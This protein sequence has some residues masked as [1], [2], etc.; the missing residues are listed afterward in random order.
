MSKDGPGLPGGTFRGSSVAGAL[1]V[2]L[3]RLLRSTLN[4][5]FILIFLC[6]ELDAVPLCPVDKEVIRSQEVRRS[7]AWDGAASVLG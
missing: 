6:R 3:E 2:L 7:L 1:G 4:S 5:G